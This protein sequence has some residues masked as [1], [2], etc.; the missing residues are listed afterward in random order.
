MVLLGASSDASLFSW[1]YSQAANTI[2][3][4][5]ECEQA[6]ELGAINSTLRYVVKSHLTTL[7]VPQLCMQ[8]VV[9][10]ACVFFF[11][12]D[13]SNQSKEAFE[14]WAHHDDAQDHFCGLDGEMHSETGSE[15]DTLLVL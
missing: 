15:D 2:R 14:D 6:H 10:T 1:Q 4:I 11:Y 3:D 12:A 7:S 5:K 8:H 13:Y 9:N